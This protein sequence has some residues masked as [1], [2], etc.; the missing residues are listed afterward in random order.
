[1]FVFFMLKR[2]STPH[3]L[4]Y[5]KTLKADAAGAVLGL[6]T[7]LFVGYLALSSV[8]ACAIDLSDLTVMV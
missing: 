5:S 1:M 7:G 3:K 8:G 4:R 6:I 2:E